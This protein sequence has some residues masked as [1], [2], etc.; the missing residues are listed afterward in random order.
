MLDACRSAVGRRVI[1]THGTDTMIE[2]ALYLKAA[3]ARA[4]EAAGSKISSSAPPMP[5]PA[6]TAAGTPV[7]A[8]ASTRKPDPAKLAELTVLFTGAMRPEKFSDSDAPLNIGAALASVALLP[9]GVYVCMHGT[10]FEADAVM[11][12]E[13]S[14]SFIVRE[15]AEED[16]VA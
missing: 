3:I 14:G 15:E 16:E 7:K 8:A 2:S 5:P 11:R 1:I 9:P 13:A 4:R 12:V 6:S 10:V